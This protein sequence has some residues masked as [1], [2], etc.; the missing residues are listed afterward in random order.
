M[1]VTFYFLMRYSHLF[2]GLFLSPFVLVFA[3]SVL[4]LNHPGIPLG[5][6]VESATTTLRVNFPSGIEKMD[7]PARVA[8]ARVILQ[9]AG[10]N[11]EI[12][13][14]GYSADN[15]ILSIPVTR[16]GYEA[17]IDVSM[18]SGTAVVKQRNTGIGEGLI[19]LHKMPGP[20]LAN[21]RRNWF[22]TRVWGWLS[23]GTAWLILFLSAS[24]IYLWV[25]LK[26]ERKTGLILMI[27]GVVCLGGAL[28]AIFI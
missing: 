11:G 12:G 16:P 5:S 27:G 23:D 18:E 19:F 4:L 28:Y 7:P 9:Q 22:V 10:I 24:G 26:S 8:Q 25:A 14:I 21:I 1:R 2:V 6:P 20:H 17:R 15:R 13:F 3:I